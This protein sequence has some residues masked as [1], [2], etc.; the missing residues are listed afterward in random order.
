[1]MASIDDSST[2]GATIPADISQQSVSIRERI[3]RRVLH[4]SDGT[5][6]EYS[7]DETTDESV[8][9]SP[10]EAIDEVHRIF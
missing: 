9:D 4:F 2:S 5:I 10:P 8:T 6:E 1:M 3:P 7:D